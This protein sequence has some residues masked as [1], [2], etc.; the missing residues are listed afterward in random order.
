[1][2]K[3]QLLI[4]VALS[5]FLCN[6]H[7][8]AQASL[9]QLSTPRV[10]D[11][12]SS[13][14]AILQREFEKRCLNYPPQEVFFRGFKKEGIIELWVKGNNGEFVKF[15]EYPICYSSGSLG[16]KRKQGDLQVPEGFYYISEFNP[17]SSYFLS[18]K[19]SY[20]NQSDRIYGGGYAL[21]GDIYIHGDC[22]TEGCLPMT[23]DKIKELYWLSLQAFNNG[24]TQVPIHIFPYKF[25]N[26]KNDQLETAKHSRMPSLLSFWDNLRSGYAYFEQ[27]HRLPNVSVNGDGSYSFY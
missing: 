16:P 24:Q 21:G 27:T 11:A 3:A 19:I 6:M 10:L 18:M 25:N 22:V 4:I 5:F 23:N 12:R 2:K 8:F 9:A 17:V 13:K 15:K 7:S 20:P 26:T 14:D 1:M